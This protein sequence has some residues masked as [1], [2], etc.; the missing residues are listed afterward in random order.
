MTSH[1]R[2]RPGPLVSGR[3]FSPSL[4][5]T[6]PSARRY[7]V[8]FNTGADKCKSPPATR[9]AAHRGE[10]GVD[11][12]ESAEGAG[13]LLVSAV[14]SARLT[15]TCAT[16]FLA[17]PIFSAARLDRSRL[18]PRTYGPR[19]LIRTFTELPVTGLVTTTEEPIGKVRDA[20]VKSLGW[21][22]APL[23]VASPACAVPGY[24]APT[25]FDGV[26][27][28]CGAAGKEGGGAGCAT[29]GAGR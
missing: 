19:S 13:D 12:D 1:D 26:A 29:A 28:V 18:R 23:A 14:E 25:A 5:H 21:W 20:A 15:F 27:L 10:F 24:E 16:P 11:E 17:I 8:A 6:R 3:A 2:S 9:I 7:G 4:R 22:G